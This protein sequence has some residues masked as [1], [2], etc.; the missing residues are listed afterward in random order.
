MSGWSTEY[1]SRVDDAVFWTDSER[2]ETV[3][4]LYR[5]HECLWNVKS[6]KYKNKNLKARAKAD[7]GNH[8]GWTGTIISTLFLT[9]TNF[10]TFISYANVVIF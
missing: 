4:E 8:F 5:S 1:F 6:S 10:A 7:I 3:I 2:I 9:T